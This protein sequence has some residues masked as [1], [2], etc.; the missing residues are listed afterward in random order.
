V[1]ATNLA[2]SLGSTL[3]ETLATFSACEKSVKVHEDVDI[4]SRCALIGRRQLEVKAIT[5]VEM[6]PLEGDD[7]GEITK[8]ATGTRITYVQS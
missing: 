4:V 7:S 6:R 2:M 5:K 3:S 8:N 1:V